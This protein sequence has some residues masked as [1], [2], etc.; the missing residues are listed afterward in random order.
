MALSF[1]VLLTILLHLA[2]AGGRVT[3]PLL[4]LTLGASPAAVG[5]MMSLLAALPMLFSVR[6]GREVDRIGARKP[7]IVGAA[8]MVLALLMAL[9]LGAGGFYARRN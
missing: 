4:A 1:V 7:M 5:V 9:A 2:Y 8:A 6:A 3:L